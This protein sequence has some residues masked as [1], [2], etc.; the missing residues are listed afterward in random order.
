MNMIR[1]QLA[2]LWL[3]LVII[4]FPAAVF[5]SAPADDVTPVGP[6]V[7]T[8][9]LLDLDPF[10]VTSIIGTIIPF[11][12]A[13][14]T[15]ATVSAAFKKFITAVLAAVGGIITVG[16]TDGGGAVVSWSSVKAALL[17]IGAAAASYVLWL[18]NS[19]TEAKLQAVG[20]AIGPKD[21]P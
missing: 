16:A 3:A 4:L 11:L 20:P 21:G 1:S 17:T 6:D 10:I 19:K 12:V 18:R 7:T 8:D 13:L 15:D 9:S 5:A 2:A 14:V